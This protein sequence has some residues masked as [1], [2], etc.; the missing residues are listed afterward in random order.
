ML[1][2]S[3]YRYWKVEGLFPE[4]FKARGRFIYNRSNYLDN[5]LLIHPDDSLVIL[6]RAGSAA[7]WRPASSVKTGNYSTGFFIV[8]TLKRGEYTLAV[9]DKTMVGEKESASVNHIIKISPNPGNE[10]FNISLDFRGTGYLKVINTAG[11]IVDS[12]PLSSEK[13]DIKWVPGPRGKGTYIFQVWS[14]KK[15]LLG[16]AKGIYS[17]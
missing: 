6:F 7:D 13:R 8:D 3:D 15:R 12:I 10:Y 14:G 4:G 11:V 16:T 9:Y 1:R 2:L 17:N 5:T